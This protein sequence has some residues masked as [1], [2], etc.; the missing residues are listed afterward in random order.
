MRAC[1]RVC[2]RHLHSQRGDAYLLSLKLAGNPRIQLYRDEA[3]NVKG[4]GKCTY[5]RVESV[6]LALQLLDD[7][8]YRDGNI[9]HLER[10]SQKSFVR[11]CVCVRVRACVRVISHSFGVHC[12]ICSGQVSKE[13]H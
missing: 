13:G 7:T 5:L 8:D 3:G 4:D 12:V 6:S 2:G 1:V 11:A 10:V 9:V